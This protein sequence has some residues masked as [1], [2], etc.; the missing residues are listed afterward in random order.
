MTDCRPW[1]ANDEKLQSATLYSRVILNALGHWVLLG[2]SVRR[3]VP[4][5]GGGWWRDSA[6]LAAEREMKS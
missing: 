2:N 5:G 1:L 4:C 3:I 6:M